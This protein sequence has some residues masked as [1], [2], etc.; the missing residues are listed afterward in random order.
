MHS[1]RGEIFSAASARQRAFR[2][3]P[4]DV[5]GRPADVADRPLGHKVDSLFITAGTE[6]G[7]VVI[8]GGPCTHDLPLYIKNHIQ[9]LW[10][11]R[12]LLNDIAVTSEYTTGGFAI[13]RQVTVFFVQTHGLNVEIWKMDLPIK[14]VYRA[15]LLGSCRIPITWQNKGDLLVMLLLLWELK[16]IMFRKFDFPHAL[17]PAGYNE[18]ISLYRQEAMVTTA[19]LLNKLRASATM[20]NLRNRAKFNTGT[21]PERLSRLVIKNS[22]ST[23]VVGRNTKESPHVEFI[24]GH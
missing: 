9:G 10:C 6:I 7:L 21:Q 19:D 18:Y 13:M 20:A 22:Q 2:R 11:M 23:P 4:T 16:V 12:D 8:S 24:H 3:R 5:E 15:M 1:H 17:Y 14:G